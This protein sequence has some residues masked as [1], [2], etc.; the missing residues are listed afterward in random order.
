M[1]IKTIK[2]STGLTITHKQNKGKVI[3]NVEKIK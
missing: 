1:I 2:T 3:I